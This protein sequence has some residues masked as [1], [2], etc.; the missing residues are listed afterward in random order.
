[1]WNLILN[2]AYFVAGVV[3]SALALAWKHRRAIA[4]F[5]EWLY[6]AAEDGKI[7]KE[8]LAVLLEAIAKYLKGRM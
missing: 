7:S 2:F 5:I 3:L 4:I 1:M 8:E 6:A